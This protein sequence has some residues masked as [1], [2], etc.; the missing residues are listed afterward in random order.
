MQTSVNGNSVRYDIQGSGPWVTL[1]HSLACSLEMWDPQMPALASAYTVLRYDTRGHG[2]SG[3][4]GGA[5]SFEQL[6]GDVIG[7]LDA[8]GVERTHFVGLSMG[9][10]IGQHVALRAPERLISLTL[11]DTTSRY[12][13]DALPVWEERIRL[14]EAKGMEA[15]VAGTLE[16]W[17]TGPYRA[18][19]TTEVARVGEL[20]RRTPVAGYVG[21]SRAIP[22]IDITHR[23]GAVRIPTL[24]I[25]GEQD[26]GTPVSMARE[27]A[28]AIP[29]AR[30]EIL[31]DAAHLAN[32]EQ[33]AAFNGV[34][35]DFLSGTGR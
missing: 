13:A 8:L 32:I 24:V 9:G 5:Y 1:S 14:V 18:E 35:L 11:A 19:R 30:L 16:R 2:G 34:L 20:I 12:P 25:V 15:V 10:M 23:L 31:P 27:I 4:P 28:G 33:A 21:C 26:P 3:A 6:A 17:F 29:G 7:L 22:T